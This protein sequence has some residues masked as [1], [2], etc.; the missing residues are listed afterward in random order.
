VASVTKYKKNLS[1]D[2]KQY[3]YMHN[4]FDNKIPDLL[5]NGKHSQGINVIR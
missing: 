1:V 5:S 2:H 3:I 4:I